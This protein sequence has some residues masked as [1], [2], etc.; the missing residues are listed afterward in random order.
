MDFSSF[1]WILTWWIHPHV[2]LLTSCWQAAS[3]WQW[4]LRPSIRR[5][6]FTGPI[7]LRALTGMRRWRSS[8]A[9]HAPARRSGAAIWDILATPT[10]LSFT[11]SGGQEAIVIGA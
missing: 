11:R 8:L 1:T 10:I 3:R 5:K 9:I 7:T 2:L 6:T 4:R